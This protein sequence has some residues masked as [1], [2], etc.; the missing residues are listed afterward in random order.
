[1]PAV[2][3]EFT[4]LSLRVPAVFEHEVPGVN[5]TAFPHASLPGC[6]DEM[7]GNN[8]K[9]NS[10]FVIPRLIFVFTDRIIGGFN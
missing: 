7:K 5:V 2:A 3:V 9:I 10:L 4:P 1:M 8:K 6:A